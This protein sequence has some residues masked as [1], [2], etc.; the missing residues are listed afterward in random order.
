[1]TS[2]TKSGDEPGALSNGISI[3][4]LSVALLLAACVGFSVGAYVASNSNRLSSLLRDRPVVPRFYK[5]AAGCE[6]WRAEH[7]SPF[8]VELDKDMLQTSSEMPSG[9]WVLLFAGAWSGPDLQMIDT[10]SKAADNLGGDFMVG[11]V[12]CDHLTA[13]ETIY[14]GQVADLTADSPAWLVVINGK[15]CGEARGLLSASSVV[16]LARQSVAKSLGN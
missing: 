1:M 3:Q 9:A 8:L 5:D 12:I 13:A 4:L 6:R 15:I 11:V 10:A 16:D 2:D 14:K 7:K